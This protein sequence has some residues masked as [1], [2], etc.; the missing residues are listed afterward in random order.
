VIASSGMSVYIK[1][2]EIVQRF[3]ISVPFP[4]KLYNFINS[5]FNDGF[6]EW[7]N[8]GNSF[9]IR[10][11]R[12]LLPHLMRYFNQSKFASFQRRLN[13]HGF[14][15]IFEPNVSGLYFH[16]KFI[17]GREDLLKEIEVV[18]SQESN[19]SRGKRKFE[20]SKELSNAVSRPR[21]DPI[22][23]PHLVHIPPQLE[24]RIRNRDNMRGGWSVVGLFESQVSSEMQHSYHPTHW[25][26]TMT[27]GISQID[28]YGMRGYGASQSSSLRY[29][30]PV[31]ASSVNTSSRGLF[32][33]WAGQ[34]SSGGQHGAS[35]LPT[36]HQ[37][38][39]EDNDLPW[40]M[41]D[42]LYDHLCS[43]VTP[44]MYRRVFGSFQSAFF[45][46]PHSTAAH[47]PMGRS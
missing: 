44:E 46:L 36:G 28:E 2:D 29:S 43:L 23:T 20:S 42:T 41:T 21:Q 6:L 14:K 7:R 10:N 16:P 30:V 33:E 4:V 15:R 17:N 27:R 24:G 13:I 22:R 25:S 31:V 40:Y 8:D 34:E 18:P 39:G 32:Q 35:S 12:G 1:V 38:R 19:M 5:Q 47:A 37:A 11:P 3:G 26:S 45:R 9:Q